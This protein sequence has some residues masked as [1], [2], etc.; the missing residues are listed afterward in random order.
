MQQNADLAVE[1][2]QLA[3]NAN[4]TTENEVALINAKNE[5][6]AITADITGKLSEQKVNGTTLDKEQLA[7][8]QTVIDSTV[9]RE[10]A[11]TDATNSLI[12]N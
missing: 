9:A 8:D 2:A 10:I 4:K 11:N 1:A 12:D 5:K 3:Y 7:I 6:L